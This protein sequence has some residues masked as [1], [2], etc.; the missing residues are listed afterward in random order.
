MVILKKLLK[1]QAEKNRALKEENQDREQR[2]KQLQEKINLMKD[3][4]V[5]LKLL[6][7]VYDKKVPTIDFDLKVLD[8]KIETVDKA[9]NDI[10]EGN[11]MQEF[12]RET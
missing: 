4:E 3:K 10:L 5:K 1:V 6:P 12:I 2:V 9:L 7:K 8:E 11:D